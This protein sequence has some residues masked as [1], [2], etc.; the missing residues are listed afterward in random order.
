MMRG[1]PGRCSSYR[2]MSPWRRKRSRHLPTVWRLTP[3]R[4]ATV[5]LSRPSAHSSTIWARRTRP[6]GRL[7]DRAIDA[8]SS[9]VSGL[10]VSGGN[11]RPRGMV[12]P[13]CRWMRGRIPYLRHYAHVLTGCNTRLDNTH[14]VPWCR[15]SLIR[16]TI[17]MNNDT[18]PPSTHMNYSEALEFI[19]RRIY[20]T[21]QDGLEQQV[22]N[23]RPELETAA[24]SA[25]DEET[26]A[27][28]L[29]I[30][31][32]LDILDSLNPLHT[33]GNQHTSEWTPHL[34]LD[35]LVQ[36]FDEQDNEDTN[37]NKDFLANLLENQKHSKTDAL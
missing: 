35:Q 32:C 22:R 24:N 4:S 13:S 15:Q 5:L 2:P 19:K 11:G 36:I 17:D 25:S 37:T 33:T 30:I 27:K 6:A 29:H 12:S 34:N 9:G 23:Y 16:K 28:A 10:M 18:I 31:F 26:K 1:R 3:T 21:F 8:S 20:K 14:G 7:R